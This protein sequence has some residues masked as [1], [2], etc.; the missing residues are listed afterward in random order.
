MI[1]F[2]Y[3]K[4]V[5]RIVV[6]GIQVV[7]V[8]NFSFKQIQTSLMIKSSLLVRTLYHGITYTDRQVSRPFVI[9]VWCSGRG[10]DRCPVIAQNSKALS[11]LLTA[12]CQPSEV[13]PVVTNVLSSIHNYIP[14]AN[15]VKK[16]RKQNLACNIHFTCL[17]LLK[18]LHLFGL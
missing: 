2:F 6:V 16:F 10:V 17:R 12:V 4:R 18:G 14:P 5:G 7:W 15:E 11:L 13:N 3:P 9:S 8:M 1:A